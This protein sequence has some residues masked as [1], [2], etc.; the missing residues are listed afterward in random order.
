[1]A[2]YNGAGSCVV[3]HNGPETTD[4][5]LDLVQGAH[6]INGIP[7]TLDKNPLAANDFRF[8]SGS[9]TA[10]YDT[11][12]HNTGV[13]PGGAPA[14]VP[15]SEDIGRGGNVPPPFIAVDPGNADNTFPIPLSWGTLTVWKLNQNIIGTTVPVP[16]T[17]MP[18]IPPLPFGLRPSDTAPIEGRVANNGAFKTPHLR[19]VELTGPYMHNGGLSTLHQVVEFYTRGG[20]F[21]VTNL[22]DFDP[23]MM[24][25]GLLIGS[26]VR[27]NELVAFL[28]AMTDQRVKNESAPFDH[29]ELFLPIDANAPVSPDGT[30]NGFFLQAGTIV[31]PG[32]QRLPQVGSAGRSAQGLAPVGTFLGLNPLVP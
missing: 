32:F 24:P 21:P 15:N 20:D 1:M 23:L 17:L 19:N 22:G 25:I 18:F 16:S 30:R 6:P 10:F 12:F 31:K 14:I 28:V 3:C 29:P 8:F 5:G 9:G 27:K 2:T 4:A 13:R 7:Q 11:P 26:D